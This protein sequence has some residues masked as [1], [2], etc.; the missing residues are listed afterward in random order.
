M[1]CYLK[2]SKLVIL[3]KTDFMSWNYFGLALINVWR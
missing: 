2:Y 1:F 3:G